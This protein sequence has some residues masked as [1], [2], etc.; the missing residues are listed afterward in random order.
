MTYP[1]RSGPPE[2]TDADML[3][4]CAVCVRPLLPADWSTSWVWTDPGGNA[5]A[6]H[7]DCLHRLGERDLGLTP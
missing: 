3:P 6:A 4:C 1:G 7:G 2:G 5:V